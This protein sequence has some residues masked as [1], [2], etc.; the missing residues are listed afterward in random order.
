LQREDYDSGSKEE[1]LT[2]PTTQGIKGSTRERERGAIINLFI[3][4]F[5][6]FLWWASGVTVSELG[7][8]VKQ[9]ETR[10]VHAHNLHLLR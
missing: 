4:Y 1:D 5:V 3:F 7:E 9:L 8:T 10:V 2:Q 6:I